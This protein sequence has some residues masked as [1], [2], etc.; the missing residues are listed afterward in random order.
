MIGFSKSITKNQANYNKDGYYFYPYNGT[1]YGIGLSGASFTTGDQT[2]GTIYGFKY[3]K[4]KGEITI[5]KNGTLLGVAVKDIKNLTLYP[6]VDF[7][8]QNS[9]VEFVKPNFK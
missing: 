9:Q 4:S 6:A 1:L 8:T 5:Y 2:I 7:Y 3:N